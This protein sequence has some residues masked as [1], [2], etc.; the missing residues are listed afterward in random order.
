L[1]RKATD[2]RGF[3]ATYAALIGVAACTV[4]FGGDALLG[5]LTNAVQTLAGVLLPSATVFLLLLCN[6]KAVLGPWVNGRCLNLFTGAVIWILVML[7]M[8]LT[9]A[10]AFPGLT[11]EAIVAILAG[12]TG[13]GVVGSGAIALV[14]RR[15]SRPAPSYGPVLRAHV[16]A[17]RATWRMPPLATLPPASLSL[18][19]R[20]W[21]GI[22]RAYLIAAVILMAVKVVQTA[23]NL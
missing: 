1:H 13:L 22:L 23:A 20:A 21:M 12:G 10:T 19:K 9:A 18:G 15:V 14:R 8:I 17:S 6:D 7:S 11:G 16:S 5:M 3:Y 2:A 4:A